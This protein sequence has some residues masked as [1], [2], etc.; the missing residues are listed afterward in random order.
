MLS[1]TLNIL[2]AVIFLILVAGV[3]WGIVDRNLSNAIIRD[4]EK[5]LK[6]PRKKAG[7]W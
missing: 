2:R 1:G 3:M 5:E 4:Q 6:L 7:K